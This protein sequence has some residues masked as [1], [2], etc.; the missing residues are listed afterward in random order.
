MSPAHNF[1]SSGLWCIVSCTAIGRRC[2]K[3]WTSSTHRLVRCISTGLFQTWRDTVHEWNTQK[4]HMGWLC[5]QC[6]PNENVSQSSYD[7]NGKFDINYI[8]IECINHSDF[9]LSRAIIR[10]HTVYSRIHCTMRNWVPSAT[11]TNSSITTNLFG[12]FGWVWNVKCEWLRCVP[13]R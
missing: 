11:G 13:N 12:Q 2:F 4:G 9:D 6:L 5:V 7:S 1:R 10:S 3:D 8:P